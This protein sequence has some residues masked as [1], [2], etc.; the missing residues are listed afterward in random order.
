MDD[1]VVKEQKKLAVLQPHETGYY[2]LSVR[3]YDQEKIELMGELESLFGDYNSW[4]NRALVC[5]YTW[6]GELSLLKFFYRGFADEPQQ[7]TD[8]EWVQLKDQYGFDENYDLFRLPAG[9]MNDVL[10]EYF[11]IELKDLEP[12]CFEGL[13]Y[14]E[15]TNCYY[16]M[17]T[18]ALLAENVTVLSAETMEDG[19][20]SM[21]YTC[22]PRDGFVHKMMLR[23]N[24][25]GYRILSNEITEKISVK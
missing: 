23:S 7:P 14:L 9:K 6:P 11:G 5:E 3:E 8:A 4:Y 16:F 22:L 10:K 13:V 2:I 21:E 1:G 12:E 24:G 19:T 20:I 15:S 18:G 25:D 17:A